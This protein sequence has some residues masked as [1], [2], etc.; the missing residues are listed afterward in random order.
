MRALKRKVEAYLGKSWAK[1]LLAA[2][3]HLLSLRKNPVSRS[4]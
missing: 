1:G 4:I 3:D 2:F